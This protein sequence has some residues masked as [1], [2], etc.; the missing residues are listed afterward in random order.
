MTNILSKLR[1][2]LDSMTEK[3]V[4]RQATNSGVEVF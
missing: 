3:S 1:D 2:R 4:R